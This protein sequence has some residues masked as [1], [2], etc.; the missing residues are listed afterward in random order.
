MIC[1]VFCTCVV[2]VSMVYEFWF[3]FSVTKS[4]VSNIEVSVL[5]RPCKNRSIKRG[6]TLIVFV[7]RHACGCT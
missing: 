2:E 7:F 5:C 4:S 3:K 1:S 6:L